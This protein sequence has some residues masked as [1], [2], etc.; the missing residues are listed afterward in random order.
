MQDIK[1]VGLE[2]EE[3]GMDSF[4]VCM[5]GFRDPKVMLVGHQGAVYEVDINGQSYCLK[6]I[7]KPH[8]EDIAQVYQNSTFLT[9]SFSEIHVPQA[10]VKNQ[11]V[12]L[13]DYDKA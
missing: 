12:Y 13:E 3:S 6:T 9:Q 1:I 7:K 5:G 4:P 2:A 10:L 8:F 11:R